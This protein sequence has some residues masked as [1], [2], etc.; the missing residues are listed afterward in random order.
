ME[1]EQ[2]PLYILLPLIGVSVLVIVMLGPG[3]F[4]QRDIV[5]SRYNGAAGIAQPPVA[6]SLQGAAEAI[7]QGQTTSD[8]PVGNPLRSP[9]SIITQGYGVGTHAPAE[10]W[11]AVDLA[12]DGDGDGV[13]GSPADLAASQGAPIYATH[14]GVVRVTPNSVPAGNHVWVTG[15]GWKTGYA[16]LSSFSVESGQTVQRGDQIG[17]VGST[18]QSSGPHLD[19]QV[20]AM[21]DG[22]WVNHNPLE[23]SILP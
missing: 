14:R 13:A 22:R 9:R 11:G 4:G 16:H 1:R 20:W 18:G 21:E 23:F 17:T 7:G 6:N 10:A 2:L 5:L 19:Y 3:L 15:D 12:I 8:R